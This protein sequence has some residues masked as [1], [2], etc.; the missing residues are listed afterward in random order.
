[1]QESWNNKIFGKG[2]KQNPKSPKSA[3]NKAESAVIKD[4]DTETGT[5]SKAKSPSKHQLKSA[6]K[7][8]RVSD[9]SVHQSF[10]RRR[11][12]RRTQ[13][14]QF[15]VENT[16]L[17]TFIHEVRNYFPSEAKPNQTKQNI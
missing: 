15:R 7:A 12:P 4:N 9:T 17:H 5:D 2:V 11:V 8:D 16:F 6:R 10:H 14:C 3:S 13:V 1:M